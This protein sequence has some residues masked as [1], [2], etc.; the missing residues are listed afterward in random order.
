MLSSWHIQQT[1]IFIPS[2]Q[3][4]CTNAV[5]LQADIQEAGPPLQVIEES[6]ARSAGTPSEPGTPSKSAK[7]PQAGGA[8]GSGDAAA[9]ARELADV[10]KRFLAVAK[11]KQAEYAKKVC[12]DVAI[13]GES[14]MHVVL[15]LRKSLTM[16]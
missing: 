3:L 11:K 9:L 8:A 1:P 7:S 15:L 13:M 4:S 14:S 2:C 5:F 12:R 16:T 6:A 10:K